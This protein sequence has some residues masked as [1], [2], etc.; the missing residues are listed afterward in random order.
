MRSP[1]DRYVEIADVR[2]LQAQVYARVERR[3]MWRRV[4]RIAEI[5]GIGVGLS[6]FWW[7][8]IRQIAHIIDLH[9]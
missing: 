4:R 1:F 3:M 5:A 9:K 7:V 2:T 8:V 6:A